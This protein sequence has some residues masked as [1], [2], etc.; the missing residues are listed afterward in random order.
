MAPLLPA[1]IDQGQKSQV[2]LYLCWYNP[3]ANRVQP[4][5][6]K[7]GRYFLWGTEYFC[8][9]ERLMNA[10]RD[11]AGAKFE[12]HLSGPDFLLK[13]RM[14]L[15]NGRKVHAAQM[16]VM[17]QQLPSLYLFVIFHLTCRTCS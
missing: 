12:Y 10:I 11:Y 16:R 7:S 13:F 8:F 17:K 14:T 4:V 1:D 3:S 15:D 6:T 5:R 9:P 2:S